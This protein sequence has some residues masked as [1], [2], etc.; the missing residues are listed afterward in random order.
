MRL[1]PTPILTGHTVPLAGGLPG[2]LQTLGAMRALVSAYRVH[3]TIRQAATSAAFLTP[4]RDEFSECRA[5]FQYVRD[6]IRYIRDVHD[7]ET[8]STPD[9]TLHGMI[10]DCDD[11]ATLLC[12]MF[13]S[14]G[15]PTRFVVAGYSDPRQFD[16][17]Y[18][19]VFACGQW[20]DCD[21]TEHHP[22]GWSPPDPYCIAVETV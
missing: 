3:P 7:V 19:Q 14:I 22:F 10:G 5:V 18:A 13:E 2:V 16:H 12:A 11:Q 9:K 1:A 4:E 15:Y 21:P 6:S 8:L 20:I 17:V